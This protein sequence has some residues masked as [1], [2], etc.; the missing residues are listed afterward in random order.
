M[1]KHLYLSCL[2]LLSF[3]SGVQAAACS[4]QWQVISPTAPADQAL[5]GVAYGN[6]QFVAVG[7]NGTVLRSSD[8]LN[9]QTSTAYVNN[10]L[11]NFQSIVWDGKEFVA[12]TGDGTAISS[13]GSHWEIQKNPQYFQQI[14]VQGTTW[15][16]QSHGNGAELWTKVPGKDWQNSLKIENTANSYSYINKLISDGSQFIAIGSQQQNPADNPSQPVYKG[17]LWISSDGLN[18][19]TQNMDASDNLYQIA[20]NGKAYLAAAYA[21]GTA[22]FRT[23]QQ[24]WYSTDLVHWELL[25]E[26]E[27]PGKNIEYLS[28]FKDNFM[29]VVSSG[30]VIISSDGKNWQT[31]PRGSLQG[32]VN[33]FADNGNIAVMST[34][35]TGI[36]ISTDGGS[37]W[38]S[39]FALAYN[40]NSLAAGTPGFVVLAYAGRDT[41]VLSSTDGKTW[42]Q[43]VLQ[44]VNLQNVIWYRQ[45]FIAY[46][47]QNSGTNAPIAYTS[48]DG[49]TWQAHSLETNAT[50]E[51]F[52]ASNAVTLQ[53]KDTLLRVGY[54]AN[55]VMSSPDG[56][57][58]QHQQTA[59]QNF[60]A[61]TGLWD[62]QQYIL[63]GYSY[64]GATQLYSSTNLVNWTSHSLGNVYINIKHLAYDGRRYLALAESADNGYGKPRLLSSSDLDHWTD[65][66]PKILSDSPA[67]FGDVRLYWSGSEFF[68]HGD[69]VM[70]STDG[71]HWQ[72]MVAPFANTIVRQGDVLVGISG[73]VLSR[74]ECSDAPAA[75][76]GQQMTDKLWIRALIDTDYQFQRFNYIEALWK[77]GGEATTA[78]GD[79]VIWGYFYA[80]PQEVDWGSEDNPELF[81]KI[82][83]DVSGR[84]DVNYFHVSVPRIAVYS[85][86]FGTAAQPDLVNIASTEDRYVRHYFETNGQSAAEVKQEDGIS[87]EYSLIKD[88]PQTHPIWASRPNDRLKIATFIH[89]ETA[90]LLPGLWRL[91]GEA[92]TARGDQVAWGYFYADPQAVNW[93][94]A[95]NPEVFV[96][97]WYDA[98]GRL[99]VN[100]FHVSVPNVT[101]YS[102]FLKTGEAL[103]KY[104]VTRLDDR[105]TRHEFRTR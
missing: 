17:L 94:D 34:Y 84:V 85:A 21:R 52:A 58:W 67:Y 62:G 103:V 15:V 93:G 1:V 65:I 83:F 89:T 60:I 24:H 6:G 29:A 75:T 41:E 49:V 70:R 78:R 95:N 90:S 64:S 96:K 9:W 74:Q 76:G 14:A 44:G 105:Y 47:A 99:D 104:G 11:L 97:V 57:T 37:T 16:A 35:G 80:N 28:R 45:Q 54:S 19:R 22:L 72:Q 2:L 100:Y 50:T 3:T 4:G 13:D 98:S 5:A 102:D 66:S 69:L 61:N 43:Q 46:G 40:Q 23:L 27:E 8:G 55:T 36:S 39:P 87:P 73:N 12:S 10:A 33:G 32:G 92:Q 25:Y 82:W 71:E 38:F 53:S 7:Y 101:V 79:K 88:A 68:L 51:F 18:W 31:A 77:K 48:A 42:R 59:P 56:F 63:G 91:G 30:E 81:V 26:G 20:Y 86:Y